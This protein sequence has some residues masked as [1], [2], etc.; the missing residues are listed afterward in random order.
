MKEHL[1]KLILKAWGLGFVADLFG[2][3]L[4]S[5]FTEIFNFDGYHAPKS[6]I[7]TLPFAISILAA[8]LLIGLFNYYLSKKLMDESIAKRLGIAMG[9]ITAPWFFLVPEIFY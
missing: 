5:I 7:D 1:V 4:M 6:L 2:S 9:I 3:L 8:A